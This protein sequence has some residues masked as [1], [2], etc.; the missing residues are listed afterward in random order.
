MLKRALVGFSL[1]HAR[2][3]FYRK[4]PV[5]YVL[6]F[7]N[8]YSYGELSILFLFVLLQDKPAVVYVLLLYFDLRETSYSI[9]FYL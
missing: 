7:H 2:N 3:D 8:E 9:M 5:S 1:I 6:T 4:G